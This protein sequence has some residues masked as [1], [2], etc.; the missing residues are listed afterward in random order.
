MVLQ[1]KVSDNQVQWRDEFVALLGVFSK[2]KE[3]YIKAIA[4]RTVTNEPVSFTE[5]SFSGEASFISGTKSE[6]VGTKDLFGW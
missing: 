4:L 6:E 1:K 3:D 5:D 2:D